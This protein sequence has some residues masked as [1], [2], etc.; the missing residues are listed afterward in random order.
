MLN[1][2][3]KLQKYLLLA[4]SFLSI[5]LS[6]FVY[7]KV[8]LPDFKSVGGV[9]KDF[10]TNIIENVVLVLSGLALVF[11]LYGLVLFLIHRNSQTSSEK[12]EQDKKNI[13]WG[14]VA[15]F[16]LVTLWGIIALAQSILGVDGDNNIK[17][18]KICVNGTCEEAKKTTTGGS[19]KD[20]AECETGFHFDTEEERC[21][22]DNSNNLCTVKDFDENDFVNTINSFSGGSGKDIFVTAANYKK[23]SSG[24]FIGKIQSFLKA[25]EASSLKITCQFDDATEAAIKNFQVKYKL[26]STGTL[27]GGFFAIA[28]F[29]VL[30]KN[31]KDNYIAD[32]ITVAHLR[33]WEDEIDENRGSP[34]SIRELQTL[35][36][37][38]VL[39]CYKGEP[40]G[41]FDEATVDAVKLFQSRNDLVEDAIVGPSTRAV[42]MADF[43]KGCY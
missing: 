7:A 4:I 27:N 37:S 31:P 10:N 2:I 36:G 25:K 30:G 40:N 9:L 38:S 13:M 3:S 42:L 32:N 20:Q 24:S 17:I 16:V 6:N 43:T 11:F 12:L 26:K 5:Y 33:S 15:L 22:P 8:N 35:L 41:A 21:V 28:A 39:G 34:K 18:P 23:G 14:L 29:R 19:T 1:K